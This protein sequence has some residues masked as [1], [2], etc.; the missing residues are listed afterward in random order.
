MPHVFEVAP[1]G[2]SKCRGCSQAI[3]RGALRFGERLP[4]PFADGEMT[5]WFH[6]ICAA[7]KRPEPL[8]EALAQTTEPIAERDSIERAAQT[9]LQHRRLPRINGAE[10]SPG[11]Q[12]KCRHC[13]EPIEKG[14]WRIRLVFFEEGMFTAGGFIH[15]S[16]RDSYFETG[17][18]TDRVVQFSTDLNADQLEELKAALENA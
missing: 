17:D 3:E 15:L 10:I 16:C 11:S 6:P 12:A 2:R 4:N 1:S 7:F 14:A 5:L 18:I 13:R 9:S 8:M